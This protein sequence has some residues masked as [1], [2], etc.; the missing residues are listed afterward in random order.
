MFRNRALKVSER[1]TRS[2]RYAQ[3]LIYEAYVAIWQSI[4][5]QLDRLALGSSPPSARTLPSR[6]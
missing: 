5:E 1:F 2:A 4:H 3:F 6:P